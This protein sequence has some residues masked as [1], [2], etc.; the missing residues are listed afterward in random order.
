M[1]KRLSPVTRMYLALVPLGLMGLA[2]TVIIGVGL[3]DN[4]GPLLRAQR[5]KELSVTSLSLILVQDDASKARILDP[6]DSSSDKRKIHAYDANQA[7]LSEIQSLSHSAEVRDTLRRMTELDDRRLRPMDT[8][9]LE[10]VDAGRLD[11]AKRE[12]FSDYAPARARYEALVRRLVDSADKQAVEAARV[13]KGSNA[14]SLMSVCGVL[15]LGLFSTGAAYLLGANIDFNELKRSQQVLRDEK[16]KVEQQN[17]EIEH[18]LVAATQASRLKSE[19]LANMSHEIRT[20]MNGIIGMTELALDTELTPEQRDYLNT[21]KMSADSLLNIINDILDF[22]KI[23]AGKLTLYPVRLNLRDHLDT[24]L[25]TL[26]L[27]AYEKGLELVCD[28]DPEVPE[29]V[30]ADPIRMGGLIVNLVGNAIKF[31]ERGEIALGIALQARNSD[32]LQL[33]FTVRDTGIGIP[34]EKQKIIFDAF[35][36]ADG[37]TTRKFGGTGLGLAISARLAR[38]MGGDIWVESEP[39]QGSC[40]HFTAWCGCESEA[41][42]SELPEGDS[43]ADIPV[44][45]VCHNAT[46]R[47]VLVKMLRA[48]QMRANSAASAQEA[49]SELRSASEQGRGFSLVLT[50]ARMPDRDGFDLEERIRGAPHLAYGVI[51]MRSPGEDRGTVDRCRSLGAAAHLRKPVCRAEL[52]LAMT[53]ALS[54]QF[55]NRSQERRAPDVTR[56]STK[57]AS[58]NSRLHILLAEDNPVN[59]RLALRILEKMGHRVVVVTNGR[60][61]LNALDG[62]AFELILMDLQMPEMDGLEATAAIRAQERGTSMHIPIVALTAHAMNSD[63][64]RCLA[65]GMDAYLSKPIRQSELQDVL[66]HCAATIVPGRGFCDGAKIPSVPE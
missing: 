10:A 58:A 30:A 66:D 26:A 43:L 12:Y 13:L 46:N 41:E 49:L 51:V 44:L 36:Q 29:H 55:W 21:V 16:A 19:F 59:Q 53:A 28:V 61:A 63:R 32:R 1:I 18:L 22:S 11:E 15:L 7:I 2:V 64:E 8:S 17:A 48:W 9:I 42:R 35:S 33:H 23:E 39:G 65:S 5:L 54:G 56:D 6:N 34:L 27:R 38:L 62:Q 37:S 14:R 20:P 45:V 57:E 25:R 31:T 24:T 4:A 40:F 47:R 52:R 3:R 50:D 60:E